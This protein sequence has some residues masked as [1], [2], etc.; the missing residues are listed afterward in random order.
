MPKFA[1]LIN[2]TVTNIIVASKKEI[3]NTNYDAV[4]LLENDTIGIG[5][6]RDIN[7]NQIIDP[8]LQEDNT[9]EE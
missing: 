3:E 4:E 7:T 2:N 5:W 8:N 9:E 6:I 1:I